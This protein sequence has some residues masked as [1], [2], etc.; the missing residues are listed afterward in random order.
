MKVFQF[1]GYYRLPD[2][3][4]PEDAFA[5]MED[6]SRFF[7]GPDPEEI[8]PKLPLEVP[9]KKGGAESDELWRSFWGTVYK[10]RRLNMRAG[11]T[12]VE[13]EGLPELAHA[14]ESGE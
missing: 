12:E 6:L 4:D 1:S 2:D 3:A 13:A 14:K 8:E 11:V 5:A 7:L 10:G 9:V